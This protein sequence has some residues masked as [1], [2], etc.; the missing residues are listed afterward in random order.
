MKSLGRVCRVLVV[1]LLALVA[2][3]APRSAGLVLIK[4]DRVQPVAIA[5]DLVR[6][7]VPLHE[8]QT[9]WIAE[10]PV[11]AVA[12]LQALGCE[13]SGVGHGSG[14]EALLP[15]CVDGPR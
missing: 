1:P 10:A 13:S 12:R 11:D 8:L 3:A 7:V 14:R 5:A 6:G 4:V 9:G 15:R 2:V